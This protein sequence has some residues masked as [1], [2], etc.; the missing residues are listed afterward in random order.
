MAEFSGFYK[1]PIEER[2]KRIQEY[3]QLSEAEVSMLKNSGALALDIAERM[4]ENV[5][6]V[7]HLPFG[8]G[9]NFRINGKEYAIP[10]AVEE[11]SVIAAASNAAKLCLPEGFAAEADE[12]VMIGQVQAVGLK[13]AGK[14][15]EKIENAKV[16]IGKLA[17]ELTKS[18]GERGGGFRNFH[19]E[20]LKTARGEMLVIYF[21]VD[22]RDSMG[23]N[24]INTLLEEIAPS[25]AGILGEGT[26]RLR[27]L[28]NLA[29]RRKAKAKAVWKKDSVKEDVIEGIL[30]AYEFA[31][32]NIYRAATHNKGIMNGIDAVALATGNDWRAVEA[33]AHAYAVRNG[34][35][36]PLTHY[37]KN[38]NG[39]LVGTIEL[40]MA[41]GTVGGSIATNPVAKIALKIL[42]VKSAKELS[43][44]AA[45]VG[46]AN[47]FAALR[48]LS[49]E[50]IQKGH[51]KLHARNLA[52]I[53]GAETADEIEEVSAALEK[54]GAYKVEQAKEILKKMWENKGKK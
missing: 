50:G 18:M 41:L 34:K 3:V 32:A 6:G 40:P 51:M 35:Y 45:C 22:V 39:D 46:L 29:D 12:P 25:I 48:A 11:A 43:M 42:G 5:V 14:A 52:I 38:G 8:L 10:M 15:A 27:V 13:N 53:A 30:D 36:L 16:E 4:A 19:T 44:V 1:L 20:A 21:E 37:E 24:T 17:R 49:T 7:T 9:L 47:N 54:K 23:A 33:G 28:S 26:V 31:K 2:L